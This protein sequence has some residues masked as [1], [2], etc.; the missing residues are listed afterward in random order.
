VVPGFAARAFSGESAVVVLAKVCLLQWFGVVAVH[1]SR[2][3]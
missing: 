2:P 3:Q 1:R